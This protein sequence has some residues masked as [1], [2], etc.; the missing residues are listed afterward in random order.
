M[1]TFLKTIAIACVTAAIVGA[2]FVAA[3]DALRSLLTH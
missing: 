3:C 1:F 2:P